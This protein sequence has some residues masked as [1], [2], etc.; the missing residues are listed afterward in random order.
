MDKVTTIFYWI[1]P[2]T[3]TNRHGGQRVKERR[4]ALQHSSNQQEYL[5]WIRKDF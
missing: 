4:L 3:T 1:K 5:K 2:A